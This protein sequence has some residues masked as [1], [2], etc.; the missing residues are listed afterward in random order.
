M[1]NFNNGFPATYQTND[2]YY[3]PYQT[4]TT[5]PYYRP[6]MYPSSFTNTTSA[7]PVNY[8]QNPQVNNSSNITWVQGEAGAKAFIVPNGASM[9]L[10]DSENQVIYIKSVDSSGKPSLTILDYVDRDAQPKEQE[11]KVDETKYA[12]AEQFD[13]FKKESLKTI[14]DLSNQI[15]NMQKQLSEFKPFAN[16]NRK[17]NTNNGKSSV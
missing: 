13:S 16:V 1:A 12:T 9:A 3:P 7:V 8:Q 5:T 2:V 14:S 10:F 17:G 15:E 11:Q 6:N 4:T